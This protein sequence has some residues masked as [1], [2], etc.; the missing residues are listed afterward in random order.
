[1]LAQNHSSWLA[2]ILSAVVIGCERRSKRLFLRLAKTCDRQQTEVSELPSQR[3]TAVA[4]A[5][6]RPGDPSGTLI[7]A[8]F[9]SP[10]NDTDATARG[11]SSP[12]IPA[13]ETQATRAR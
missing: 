9:L 2:F 4:L 5:R 11:L 10:V 7:V 6:V 3:L 1:V 12:L 8:S 13:L